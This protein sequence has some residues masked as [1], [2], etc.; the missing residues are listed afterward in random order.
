ML[1]AP[2][3]SASYHHSSQRQEDPVD[4]SDGEGEWDR[5]ALLEDLHLAT[6]PKRRRM[7]GPRSWRQQQPAVQEFDSGGGNNEGDG[8]DGDGD[9]KGD[10]EIGGTLH[11]LHHILDEYIAGSVESEDADAKLKDWSHDQN[12]GG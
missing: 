2:R 11:I 6:A 3:R 1:N 9:G 8:G 5:V 10:G 4:G 12:V 7:T